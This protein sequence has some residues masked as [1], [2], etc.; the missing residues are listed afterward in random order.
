M[1]TSLV[2]KLLIAGRTF[3]NAAIPG[4]D[5]DPVGIRAGLIGGRVYLC[6]IDRA[7][8]S[9]AVETLDE[10][11]GGVHATRAEASRRGDDDFYGCV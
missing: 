7:H 1:S 5:L 8:Q 11:A 9:V 4:N 6:L 3:A 2:P 10:T